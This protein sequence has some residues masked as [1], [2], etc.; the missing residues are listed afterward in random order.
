MSS[1]VH[2]FFTV[3][4]ARICFAPNAFFI[5]CK[6]RTKCS[7]HYSLLELD[8]HNNVINYDAFCTNVPFYEWSIR[9]WRILDEYTFDWGMNFD[10]PIAPWTLFLIKLISIDW[11]RTS[12]HKQTDQNRIR[13]HYQNSH[14]L[15]VVKN[16]WM[17]ICGFELLWYTSYADHL[18]QRWTSIWDHSWPNAARW[19]TD[20]RS[21]VKVLSGNQPAS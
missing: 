3:F 1:Y 9:A 17:T 12:E 7:L 13:S 6:V 19:Y 18:P 10:A 4:L 8:I 20:I 2:L 21:Q 5:W 16:V 14:Y 11:F 15:M